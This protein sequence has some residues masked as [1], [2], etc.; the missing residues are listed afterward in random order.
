M[1]REEN[2]ESAG[3]N[4]LCVKAVMYTVEAYRC[5]PTSCVSSD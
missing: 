2:R 4:E 1:M 5:G 3:A